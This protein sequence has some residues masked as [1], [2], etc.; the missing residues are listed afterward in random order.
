LVFHLDKK[1]FKGCNQQVKS[2]TAHVQ[3]G[4]G[5]GDFISVVK[6]TG[7]KTNYHPNIDEFFKCSDEI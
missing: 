5:A 6:Y 1:G 3:K 7:K 4:N 2:K